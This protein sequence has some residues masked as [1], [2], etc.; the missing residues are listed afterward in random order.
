VIL[1]TSPNDPVFFLHHAN[2]DRR[3][4]EWQTRHPGK[5]YEP[6]TGVKGN[7]ADSPMT[8]FDRVTPGAVEHVAALG[9]R[10]E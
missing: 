5:T 1:T 6:K 8:P 2:V 10:Y 3:W 4:A 9:Y 7:A